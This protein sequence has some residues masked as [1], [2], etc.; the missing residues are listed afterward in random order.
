MVTPQHINVDAGF[1]IGIEM[2]AILPFLPFATHPADVRSNPLV[3]GQ[4]LACCVSFS[5]L[6]V[7][8]PCAVSNSLLLD[9]LLSS[10]MHV[11][12]RLLV[13]TILCTHAHLHNGECSYTNDAC[14]SDQ[15]AWL[16]HC[17]QVDLTGCD[18]FGSRWGDVTGMGVRRVVLVYERVVR[19]ESVV[20]RR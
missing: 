2:S 4:R 11:I 19:S 20:E 10:I 14:G 1:C 15:I 17:A 5:L 18:S 7:Q 13:L 3:L 12:K 9:E 16:S 8:N 6:L